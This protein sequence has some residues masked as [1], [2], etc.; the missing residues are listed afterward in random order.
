MYHVDVSLKKMDLGLQLLEN[1]ISGSGGTLHR[2]PFLQ[3][4]ARGLSSRFCIKWSLYTCQQPSVR[5]VTA[6]NGGIIEEVI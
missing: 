2:E 4:N 5:M 1:C 3:D 6:Q